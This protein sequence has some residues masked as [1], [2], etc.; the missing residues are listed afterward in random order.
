[1]LNFQIAKH[2]IVEHI[3][4]Q[5]FDSTV[6]EKILEKLEKIEDREYKNASDITMA[7][8]LVY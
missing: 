8:G 5:H 3:K 2:R 1:M 6:K 4:Q 7:A